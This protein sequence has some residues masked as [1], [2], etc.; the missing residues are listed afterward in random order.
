MT[1]QDSWRWLKGNRQG[2]FV[3]FL[4]AFLL[5]LFFVWLRL[6][7]KK[8]KPDNRPLPMKAAPEP[9]TTAEGYRLKSNIPGAL[10]TT[11]PSPQPTPYERPE[12]PRTFDLKPSP[13]P[14][15]LPQRI[16]AAVG[17][18]GV[19]DEFL[20][21]GRLVPCELVVTVDS[22]GITTPIIG[23]VTEDQ[24]ENGHL[25]I[26]AGAEVHGTCMLDRTTRDRIASDRNWTLVWQASGKE[27]PIQ[28]IALDSS[29]RAD[30]TGWDITDG[31]AGLRGMTLKSDKWAEIKEIIAKA[32]SAG[33]AGFVPT[34]T[35]V[36]PF[37]SV[38]STTTGSWQTALAQTVSAAGQVYGDKI[39]K[40]I[41]D[42]GVFVR[43]P[44]GKQFYL[45]VMQT[46]D[47]TKATRGGSQITKTQVVNESN[48]Q[49]TYSSR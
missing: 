10:A 11:G 12:S 8:L 9:A 29:P 25:I 37:G 20:P 33:A 27:L 38:S 30:G 19:S 18:E 28:G 26:P 34:V 32:I 49:T 31:S 6:P 1:I 15:P 4:A 14:K 7:E 39:E 44:A 22:S 23:M 46:V 48:E 3:L 36:G 47:L 42:D 2:R 43:V 13:T 21:Y 35:S 40:S 41:K 17:T 16:Y 45:Y 24:W 5:V